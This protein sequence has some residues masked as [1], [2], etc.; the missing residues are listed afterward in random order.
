MKGGVLYRSTYL[1]MLA[2]GAFARTEAAAHD[3]QRGLWEFL[4]VR[5]SRLS[6]WPASLKR[7]RLQLWAQ[8]CVHKLEQTMLRRYEDSSFR[9]IVLTLV[10][11]SLVFPAISSGAQ[12][13][14]FI[15]LGPVGASDAR[16]LGAS[17]GQQVGWSGAGQHAILWTGSAA[18]AT[19]LTPPGYASSYA[20]GVWGGRQVGSGVLPG[21]SAVVRALLWFGTPE[22]AVDLTPSGY[23]NSNA[24]AIDGNQ[25]VGEALDIKTDFPHALV[26]TGTAASAVDLH[27]A[28]FDTSWAY[29]T[30]GIHQ[31]G[32]AYHGRGGGSIDH[33]IFWSGS[34][35]S[36][37]DLTPPG[38]SMAQAR[39]VAGDQVVGDGI[40]PSV[41][42]YPHALLWTGGTASAVD[43]NPSNSTESIAYATTGR[44]Q[45]GY[46]LYENTAYH[47]VIWNGSATDYQDLQ[48]LLPS[49]YVASQAFGIDPTTGTVVGLAAIG[50]GGRITHAAEWVLPE[51][52]SALLSGLAAGVLLFRRVR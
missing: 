23:F 19:D 29:G 30:D 48:N 14:H 1:Y 38:F 24:T 32:V 36:A 11:W 10:G 26:W 3:L 46:I 39:G 47:A 27:P 7:G 42:P 17:D 28:G 34:A 21:P 6:A 41:S 43:L 9:R 8:T 15:D 37:V 40:H 4:K 25:E 13:Y 5:P 31:V 49:N 16:A 50:V 52:G 45:V 20:T 35:T 12:Q 18:S 33:A 51:P 44:Q 22:S 2:R